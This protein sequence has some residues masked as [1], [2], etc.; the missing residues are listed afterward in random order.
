M[1]ETGLIGMLIFI[2]CF[3]Y[4]VRKSYLLYKESKSNE[5]FILFLL[6]VSLLAIGITEVTMFTFSFFNYLL[7][8][9]IIVAVG[10]TNAIRE[11]V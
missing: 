10:S 9:L 3:A 8:Y 1:V 6:I 7:F 2:I 5:L 11:T 4:V